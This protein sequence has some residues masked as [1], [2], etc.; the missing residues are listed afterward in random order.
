VI[1]KMSQ[2]VIYRKGRGRESEGVRGRERERGRDSIW[3]RNEG[4]E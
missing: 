4:E 3:E 1:I 2:C